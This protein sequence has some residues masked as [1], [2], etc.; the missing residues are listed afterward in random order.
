M[1]IHENVKSLKKN[2]WDAFN[3]VQ[4]FY[5]NELAKSFGE[6]WVAEQA[7]EHIAASKNDS[8][9][10]V[11]FAFLNLHM[12]DLINRDLGTFRTGGFVNDEQ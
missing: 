7:L 5:S 1:K 12:L 4:P 6:L 10:K 11:L 9:K 3:A 2:A 8:N